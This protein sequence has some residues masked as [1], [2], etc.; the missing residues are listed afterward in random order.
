MGDHDVFDR[1]QF[2]ARGGASAA[3]VGAASLGPL[4]SAASAAPRLI[5]RDRIAI[6][7]FTLR[8]LLEKDLEGTLA[9]LAKTGYRQVEIAG[10]FGR[11]PQQFRQVLDA[12][13]LRAIG[14]HQLQGP[15]LGNREVEDVLDEAQALD[16][17]YVGTA[18]ISIPYG[19]V[20][21][22][23][24]PQIADRYRQLAELANAWGTAAAA[25]Q[26]RVYLHMHYWD[27]WRDL[28]TGESFAQI[29]FGRTDPRLVWFEPDLFWIVFGGIDPLPWIRRYQDRFMGFHVKDGNP[30]PSGGYFDPGFTDLGRGSINFRRLFEPLKN[31]RSH[32]YILERDNQPHPRRTAEIGYTYMRNL[33]ARRSR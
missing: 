11:T 1:R 17:R 21:G 26:M 13:G 9:F 32:Y 30:D 15:A 8:G 2:L 22:K 5:P 29:M 10:L 3:V 25:R 33:R 4:A 19:I 16:Q 28:G 18:A 14:G 6:Q 31:R 12:N 24:E 20:S 27:F 7:L 23:G